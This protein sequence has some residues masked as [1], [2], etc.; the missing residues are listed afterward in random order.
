MAGSGQAPTSFEE[1]RNLIVERRDDL[2]K[3]LTQVAA[4]ALAHPEDIAFGTA[5]SIAEAA[6]V[7][8]STLVRFS[9]AL[10]FDGF[11]GLQQV[12]QN[13]LRERNASYQ[14]RLKT[15]EAGSPAETDG[16]T[17]LHHFVAAGH[18]SLDSLARGIDPKV[19]DKAVTLLSEA[20]T[21]Y[22]LAKR[23]SYPIASYL[24]YAFGRLG[25]RSQLVSTAAGIDEDI[26]AL[27]GPKDAAL[28]ISFAPYA[29]ETAQSARLLAAAS[30]PLISLTDSALSPLVPCSTAWFELVEAD[31]AGFRSLS[32]SMA[33]AMALSVSVAEKR[34]QQG[35]RAATE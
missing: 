4:Y 5:A 11:S 6:Q 14:Q 35:G 8:P 26:L 27:A 10:G 3:R 23:R 34:R 25:I 2:P 16:T 19:F 32:A 7:Q 9:Q 18:A 21:I 24:S 28:A 22:L 31:H 20:G 17:I 12:F 33:L 13:R 30:V 15:L 29:A 1:L